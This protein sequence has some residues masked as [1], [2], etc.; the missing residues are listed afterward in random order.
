VRQTALMSTKPSSRTLKP[1]LVSGLHS[2]IGVPIRVGKLT[3]VSR[4][5][6][7]SGRTNSI[8]ERA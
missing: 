4:L 5:S 6:A 1:I 3:L 2:K 7:G 8:L